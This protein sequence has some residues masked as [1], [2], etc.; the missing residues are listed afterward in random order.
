MVDVESVRQRAATATRCAAEVV[1]ERGTASLDA[2]GHGDVASTTACDGLPVPSRCQDPASRRRTCNELQSMG[3]RGHPTGAGRRART[4]GTATP[5]PTVCR[6][7]PCEPLATGRAV[8]AGSSCAQAGAVHRRAGVADEDRHE[9]RQPRARCPSTQLLDAGRGARPRLRGVRHR[10]LV[11]R[12]AHRP[13]R[14]ARRRRGAR[15]DLHARARANAASRS[16]P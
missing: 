5:P 11:V 3:G 15:R 12:A 1:G 2:A 10:Q 13:R 9:H 6:G 7:V 8:D 4:R 14:D 16:A